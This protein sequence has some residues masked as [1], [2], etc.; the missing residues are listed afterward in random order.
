MSLGR[1]SKEEI[2]ELS[3]IDVAYEVLLEKKEP[4]SFQEII[5]EVTAALELSEDEVMEK[6]SQF[7]TELNIDGRYLCLGDNKWGLRSWYPYEQSEDEIITIVKPKKKRSKKAALLEDDLF[8]DEDELLEDEDELDEFEEFIEDEVEEDEDLLPDEE[9]AEVLIEEEFE[10]E[11]EFEE[12]DEE[13]EEI[14]KDD[15]EDDL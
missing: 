7:Y 1:F 11:E 15:D 13:E 2:K 4:V 12:E 3:M 5:A 6:V 9:V 8:D 14:F 10:L